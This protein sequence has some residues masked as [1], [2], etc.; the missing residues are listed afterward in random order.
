MIATFI[1]PG[2]LPGMNEIINACKGRGGWY[3]GSNLKKK[4]MAFCAQCIIAASVPK[5]TNPIH[6]T[7]TWVE[8]N[9]KRDIDNVQGGI[10]FI[11]DAL[12]QTLRIPDDSRKWVKGNM[13]LHPEA[14]PKDPHIVVTITEIDPS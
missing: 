4:W 10:K 11:L 3:A 7:I 6:I 2:R 13:N 5:F 14:N 8:P 9:A 1:I 12:V